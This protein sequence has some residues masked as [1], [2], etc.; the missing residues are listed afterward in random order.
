MICSSCLSEVLLFNF[1]IGELYCSINCAFVGLQRKYYEQLIFI[2]DH[3]FVE[4]IHFDFEL[5]DQKYEPVYQTYGAACAD[6][7]IRG[8]HELEDNE[9]KKIPTGFIVKR[10]PS[11][12]KI[13]VLTRGG[14]F[15]NGLDILHGTIDSDFIGEI[16]IGVKNTSDKKIELKDCDRIAQI[17][18]T[19]VTKVPKLQFNTKQ[20]NP[21]GCGST[22]INDINVENYMYINNN[23]NDIDVGIVSYDNVSEFTYDFVNISKN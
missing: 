5:T 17:C 15:F 20:R 22:G 23:V 18:F 21:D 9:R 3:E 2:Q 1:G 12:Y 4:K 14:T 6:I 13:E 16:F 8:N 19:K 10:M 7:L 11:N